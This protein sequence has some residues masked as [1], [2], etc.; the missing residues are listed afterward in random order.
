M[1]RSLFVCVSS[2]CEEEMSLLYN[3]SKDPL[4]LLQSNSSFTLPGGAVAAPK[5][6]FSNALTKNIVAMLVWLALSIIN[7]SMVHTFLRHRY[8]LQQP[9]ILSRLNM[10]WSKVG[11]EMFFY[12]AHTSLCA[13]IT[14]V[15]R[16]LMIYGTEKTRA[17]PEL[18]L[19]Q[20]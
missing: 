15:L 1:I 7:S 5:D 14:R 8:I 19:M 6:S 4:G 13:L 12:S 3:T 16:V 10:W 18:L 20:A 9:S 17:E 11:Q 2:D